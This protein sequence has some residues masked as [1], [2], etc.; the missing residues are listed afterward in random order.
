MAVDKT[1]DI[2][3]G[4]TLHSIATGNIIAHADEIMDETWNDGAGEKQS[5][6][7]QE[8]KDK[9]SGL[10]TKIEEV[11]AS[12]EQ[13][14]QDR[15]SA[16]TA[17]KQTIDGYTVNGHA[18]ST[19]PTL[20]KTDV[21]LAN[22]TNDA[23]VKRTEMGVAGGVATLDDSGKV[24]ESQLPSY[25]DDVLEY[26]DTTA[27]PTQGESGKIYVALDTDLTYR[28]SGTQ[29]VEISKSIAL[30]E[31]SSTAYAGDKGKATTDKVTEVYGA[32]SVINGLS[33]VIFDS[34]DEV[35]KTLSADSSLKTW[36]GSGESN[37]MKIP[38]ATQTKAGV[39]SKEDK[40]KLDGVESTYLKI[41]DSGIGVLATY[42]MAATAAGVVATD[43]IA[44]AIGKLE[45]KLSDISGDGE[46]SIAE[47]IQEAI[48]ALVNG[49]SAGYTTL[50]D[51][52]DAIKAVDTDLTEL[53]ERVTA[54]EGKLEVIQG[55]ETVE[56]SISKALKDAKDYTD[57][58]LTWIILD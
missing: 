35:N 40:T 4:G 32:N 31:T 44:V 41:A 43:T 52:E 48:D 5:V 27:F 51:L 34:D 30:G 12:I 29:Y 18:I 45:K 56:G 49:A 57:T 58:K 26:S 53:E 54:N 11:I 2:K 16:D 20:T 21:G 9:G 14:A 37:D 47:Q 38:Y 28:W 17:L 42:S 25:V 6:I 33:D 15:E 39:M 19:N 10:D 36:N 8:L 13:E 55:D 24:P 1:N 46:G 3:V 22:V 23:Q 7:N 50:K